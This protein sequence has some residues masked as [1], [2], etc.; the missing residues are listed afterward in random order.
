MQEC[1]KK[2]HIIYQQVYSS[3]FPK[4]YAVNDKRRI[5]LQGVHVLKYE[6]WIVQKNFKNIQAAVAEKYPE[7]Y[8]ERK[9]IN[10]FVQKPVSFSKY[11][12]VK[13]L[14]LEIFFSYNK[15]MTKS[16]ENKTNLCYKL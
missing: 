8:A 16:F 1:F 4:F 6:E 14:K 5:N 2:H 12:E 13:K 11:D 7:A 3:L 9:E 10:E 15:I